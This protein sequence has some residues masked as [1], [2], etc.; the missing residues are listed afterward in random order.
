MGEL[1]NTELEN[2]EKRKPPFHRMEFALKV[3]K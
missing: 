3:P 2:D 1:A